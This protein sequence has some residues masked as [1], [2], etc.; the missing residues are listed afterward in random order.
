MRSDLIFNL[1]NII[2]TEGPSF[3]STINL[4]TNT[5][6]LKSGEVLLCLKG[7]NFD[8]F[9]YIEEALEKNLLLLFLMTPKRERRW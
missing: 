2:F 6:T 3:S 5:K 1:S 8:A 9:D 4:S 7:E